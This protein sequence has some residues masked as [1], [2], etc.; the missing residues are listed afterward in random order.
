MSDKRSVLVL[1]VDVDDDLGRILNVRTPV[2]GEEN[3]LRL[4]QEYA[5][6][7]PEDSDVNALFAALKEYR[8]LK[9]TGDVDVDIAVVAGDQA[10]GVKANMAVLRRVEELLREK[11]YDYAIL[12]SDGPTDE[13]VAYVLKDK[14]RVEDIK[15]VV[16]QQS[17]G[18]EETFIIVTRYIRKLFEEPEYRKYSLGIPGSLVILYAALSIVLPAYLW[19]VLLLILGT[20]MLVKGFSLD[21]S[22]RNLYESRP[23]TFVAYIISAMML[24]LALVGGLQ[25]TSYIEGLTGTEYMGYFLLAVVGEQIYVADLLVVSAALP[26]VGKALDSLSMGKELSNVDVGI[27][28]FILVFRQALLE[29][30]NLMKGVGSAASFMLWT[31]ISVV[32]M[33]V[34]MTLARVIG[35][36]VSKKT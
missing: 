3:V 10:G 15:R 28:T 12:V 26:L 2:K 33:S 36:R 31:I 16:V 11:K 5:L 22:I 23:L 8:E 18:I 24:L 35:S 13:L 7:E 20:V 34:T 9:E 32:A 19:Q 14:L 27:L 21:E 6:K 30:G 29:A 25:V 1:C 4:A 17:K